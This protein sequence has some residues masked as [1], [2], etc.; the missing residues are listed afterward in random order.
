MNKNNF[1]SKPI[2]VFI[3]ALICT[4]LWGSAYPC[5]KKGYEIFNLVREDIPGKLLFAGIRFS[6]AGIITLIIYRLMGNKLII[7]GKRV[8]LGILYVGLIQ[9]FIQY[10]FFYIGLAN[11]TGVKSSILNSSVSFFSIILAHFFVKSDRINFRKSLGCVV[12]FLGIIVINIR[13]VNSGDL[14][15]TLLGDG[16]VLLA[17]LAFSVGALIAKI[18]SKDIS[19]VLITGYQLTLGGII[20][21]TT[22]LVSGGHLTFNTAAGIL[23]LTYMA[24]LSAVAFTLW[25]ILNKYN[26]MSKVAIYNFLTPVFGTVFSAIFLHENLFELQNL[27][28]LILVCGGIMIVNLSRSPISD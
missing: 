9:T 14:S 23:L 18:Y 16:S 27:L 1:F 24:C 8:S 7:P 11:T 2:N 26:D 17:A 25:T 4:A 20:L 5:I 13:G 15:F 28:A 21:M 6:A 3:F 22:G 10:I 12:G 19:P